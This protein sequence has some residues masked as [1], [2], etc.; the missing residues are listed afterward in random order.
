[1]IWAAIF[2]VVV[3]GATFVLIPFEEIGPYFTVIGVISLLMYAA[4]P[5][6]FSLL[7]FGKVKTASLLGVRDDE[8]IL[9]APWFPPRP[10]LHERNRDPA[11]NPYGP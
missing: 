5:A 8:S 7:Y 1:M 6:I 11:A 2:A 4:L 9:R 10:G 3:G